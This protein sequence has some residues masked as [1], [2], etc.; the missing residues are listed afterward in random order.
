LKL[1]YRR[2]IDGLR[3]IAV[4]AVVLYHAG[5]A[6]RAGYVGVDIFFVISGYLI[7]ALLLRE[8]ADTG[9]INL[10]DFYARRVRRIFPAAIVVTL[11]VLAIAPLLPTMEQTQIVKSA[12]AAAL[13]TA[14]LFF[15]W[16]TTGYF[17]DDASQMPLLHLWSLSVEEQ[18]YVVW[19][20][21]LI[22]ALRFRIRPAIVIGTLAVASLV[23]AEWLMRSNLNAAY[24]QMPTRFWE[25]AAGGL[26]VTVP[27]RLIPRISPW[28]G[29]GMVVAACFIPIGHFPGMGALPAVVGAMLLVA[30]IHIGSENTLLASTPMVSVGLISYSLYLWHWPL[31]AIDR[32]FRAGEAPLQVRLGLLVA[33]LALAVVSYRYIETPFRKRRISARGTIAVGCSAMAAIVCTAFVWW[34]ST[35][36]S[37]PLP[38][39]FT[40]AC[41]PYVD[42]RQPTMQRPSCLGKEPKVVT[43]G[44]SYAVAWYPM[45]EAIG[46]KLKEPITS[47]ALDGCPNLIGANLPWPWPEYAKLC[48]ESH[49]NA[50]AY[51]RANGADTLIIAN[52]WDR[53]LTSD[54]GTGLGLIRAVTAVSPYVRRIMIIGP[55]PVYPDRPEK[56]Q[57]LHLDCSVSR[58]EFDTR[59]VLAWR[60]IRRL[61]GNAKVTVV[62][63]EDFFC[64]AQRCDPF[65]YGYSLTRDGRHVSPR[66]A[67]IYADT[68]AD[69]WR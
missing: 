39:A 6:P 38:T 35:A 59:T 32:L 58:A 50:I 29:L 42:G 52:H 11:A 28:V 18:F 37:P 33:S 15:Q 27:D 12:G 44:D 1:A 19:P 9:R 46:L 49:A 26:I 17:A 22:L 67:R 40:P 62:D 61:S 66:A 24:Y 30:S 31:L 60:A 69:S 56:C 34:H 16:A 54:P 7:T 21:L 41:H 36:V 5:L 64:D 20:A 3:A 55:T 14:N 53:W 2:E 65:R 51:L 10:A 43:W 13:F 8:Y 45:A 63:P 48:P 47:L 23:S 25:L 68:I 4:L 57:A